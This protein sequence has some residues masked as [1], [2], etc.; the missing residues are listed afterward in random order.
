[1]TGRLTILFLL[2][3]AANAQPASALRELRR[4]VE[5]RPDLRGVH[6][7]V[8][9]LKLNAGNLDEAEK[10]FRAEAALTP[11]DGEAAWRLGSVLLQKGR[12]GEALAELQRSDRL[13]PRMI[14]TLFDL[15]KA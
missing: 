1:M 2:A 14:E 10:E 9:M 15:G 3:V 4:A 7:A 12:A 6:L 5:L 11:G 13:R 8:G